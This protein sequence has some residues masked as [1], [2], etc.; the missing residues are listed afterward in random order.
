MRPWIVAT[1]LLTCGSSGLAAETT[2]Q[3]A[4]PLGQRYFNLK[5]GYSLCP[6]ADSDRVQERAASRSVTWSAHDRNTGA[7]V[8]TLK[9][10]RQPTSLKEDQL[11]ALAK[12]MA[13]EMSKKDDLRPESCQVITAFGRKAID[14]RAI[15]KG[16][17]QTWFRI[18]S[19]YT[20][21][22]EFLILSITGPAAERNRL[23]AIHQAV[24]DSVELLDPKAL[25]AQ[26]EANLAA[27]REILAGLT[28]EKLTAV[29]EPKD[30][31]YLLMQGGQTVGFMVVR[32]RAMA[33]EGREGVEIK[34]WS[35]STL[36][37]SPSRQVTEVMLASV[38][39]TRETNTWAFLSSGEGNRSKAL[40]M[41]KK[42][43]KL[44]F[45]DSSTD[46]SA[47]STEKILDESMDRRYLPVAISRMIT[48]LVDLSKA[49]SYAFAYYAGNAH[50]LDVLTF[51]V[52]GNEEVQFGGQAVPAVRATVRKAED[53]EQDHLL[54]DRTGRL[55]RYESPT[56]LDIEQS[57]REEVLRRFPAA[58]EM[59]KAIDADAF[60]RP[61]AA[62]EAK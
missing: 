61:A 47:K 37:P 7:I 26:R 12:E 15:Q 55:L 31:W 58:Q 35:K 9:A 62:R 6:P 57:T 4:V 34:A 21:P 10:M 43:K 36:P 2:S 25:A 49:G 3:P 24:L 56:G 30:V 19:G 18:V 32:E 8:W 50:E 38:D 29:I 54:L 22:D 48:R 23:L 42:D 16:K 5:E 44:T 46:P 14:R 39:R 53:A 40:T 11:E 52:L 20:A 60:S 33:V 1:L 28:A 45:A 27:G 51:T 17:G 13:E 41:T 59:L